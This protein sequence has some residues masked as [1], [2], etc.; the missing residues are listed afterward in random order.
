MPV[1]LS[2]PCVSICALDARGRICLG[3]GRTIEEIGAWSTMSETERR[4]VMARLAARATTEAA[5]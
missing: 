4:A 1:A 3:C 2:T 5:R